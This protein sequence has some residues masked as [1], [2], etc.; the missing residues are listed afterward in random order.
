MTITEAINYLENMKWLKG[1]DNTTIGDKPIYCIIDSII[2][3]IKE[4]TCCKDCEYYGSCH[5][6]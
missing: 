4:K 2:D 6:D 1:Y 5:D 3:I